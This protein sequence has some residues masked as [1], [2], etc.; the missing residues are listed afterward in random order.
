VLLATR[1][2]RIVSP[3]RGRYTGIYKAT[4][5]GLDAQVCHVWKLTNGKIKSFQQYIDTAQ[6]QEV[7]GTRLGAG[8]LGVA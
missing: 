8:A 2:W 5:K 1:V 3:C 4:D 6:L 7:T